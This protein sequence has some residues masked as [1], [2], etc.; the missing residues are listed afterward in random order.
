MNLD[1]YNH[2]EN[3][4]EVEGSEDYPLQIISPRVEEIHPLALVAINV[5]NNEPPAT[6]NDVGFPLVPQANEIERLSPTESVASTPQTFDE[7]SNQSRKRTFEDEE[8]EEDGS[9][10]PICLDEW[11]NTGP[12][13]I[14]ALKCGH[15]FGEQCITRWLNQNSRKTCPTCK[16]KARRHDIRYIYAKKLTAIDTTE[17]DNIKK[18]L[19]SVTEQRNKFQTELATCAYREQLLRQEIAQLKTQLRQNNVPTFNQPM[20]ERVKLYMDKAMEICKFGGSRVFDARCELDLLMASMKSPTNLFAGFGL[21]KINI[22]GYRT[23][24]F[25]PVH[26]LQIRDICFHKEQNWVLTA[27]MDK[28]FKVI[29]NHENSVVHQFTHQ[30]PLWSCCWDENNPYE[31]YVGTQAGSVI[32]YDIRQL[33]EAV[34]T[35]SIEGDMSPVVSVASIPA[36]PGEALAQGG[37][38][39]C[40]L[41]SLWLYENANGEYKR[42]PISLEGPF[43]SMK[44]QTNTKQLLVSSRPNSR[45][46]YARHTLSTLARNE[47]K[48]DCNILHTFQGGGMQKLLSKS[49]FLSHTSDY[50]A[51]HQENCK[52]VFLWSINTGQKVC[53]VTAHESVFDLKGFQNQNGSFLVSLTDKKLEFFKFA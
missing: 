5:D 14:C 53:S 43:V 7:E 13:R 46:T 27:S 24:A 23:I 10:C 42:H 9:V 32:K 21:K 18:Q 39:S 1:D 41:N 20:V 12:H 33:T 52:S 11:T 48:I 3:E 16:E 45:I 37:V 40:K 2:G 4:M 25:I 51:A 47:G 17:L 29:N 34:C 36:A 28:T 50:V 49:C 6:Y 26:T 19:D 35:F 8:R 22:S 15:L 30:M 31:L 44:Y 38:V